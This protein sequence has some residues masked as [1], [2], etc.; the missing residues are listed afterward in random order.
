MRRLWKRLAAA[1]SI[2]RPETDPA[3]AERFRRR[4]ALQDALLPVGLPEPYRQ[5]VIN[6]QWERD[7]LRRQ[8]EEDPD[9]PCEAGPSIGETA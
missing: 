1:F 8:I 4:R 5:T 9:L 3:I 2:P 7:R 6:H